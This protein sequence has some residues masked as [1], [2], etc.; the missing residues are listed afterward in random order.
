MAS[1]MFLAL[2]TFFYKAYGRHLTALELHS[3]LGQNGHASQTI[4][5]VME[6]N[7][8]TNNDTVMTITQTAAA[9][10]AC[11]TGTASITVGSQ[12]PP[13]VQPSMLKL[14]QQSTSFQ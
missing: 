1:K 7:D 11:T 5:N 12:A 4:Y 14:R 2:K 13:T 6:G 10:A 8:N 3:T 9:I